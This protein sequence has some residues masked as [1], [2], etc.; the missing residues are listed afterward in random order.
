[1]KPGATSRQLFEIYNKFIEKRGYS[2]YS[3]YGSVHSSGML[4]CESP[5]FS[6]E[7]DVFMIENMSVCIDA[8]F[9]DLPWGAF[10][11]EDTYIIRRDGA[12]LVT[13]FN[14]KYIP[15]LIK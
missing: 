14:Q 15:E 1:M 7:K 11:I 12:E 10:R 13:K 4:E 9:K 2:K 6:A 3:P 5:F 8:Y